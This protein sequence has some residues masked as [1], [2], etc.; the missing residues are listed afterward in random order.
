MEGQI[1]FCKCQGEIAKNFELGKIE[2]F[3]AS[4]EIPYITLKDLCGLAALD[5]A[6]LR[7]L[8]DNNTAKLILACNKRAL[9][10]L[11]YFAGIEYKKQEIIVINH[12]KEQLESIK[13]NILEFSKNLKSDK[14]IIAQSDEEWPSWY[15]VID[16]DRCTHCGQ[17]ADFCLFG[18][19]DKNNAHVKVVNPQECKNL[20]PA[21]ARICPQTAIIFPKFEQGGAISG[22]DNIDEASE[23]DRLEKDLKAIT[24]GDLYKTLERRKRK[25]QSIIK[26]EVME[27]AIAERDKAL[28][29]KK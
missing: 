24:N 1:I 23:K 10:R 29:Y 26:R 7:T 18:V 11:M 17:C 20:C 21:C 2:N 16:Y 8:F 4:R 14:A 6:K 13:N 3:F 15:P 28:K 27:Q 12:R 25:R 9:E 5:K 22:T 19:Y